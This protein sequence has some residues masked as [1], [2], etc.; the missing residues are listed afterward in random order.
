MPLRSRTEQWDRTHERLLLTRFL[1]ALSDSTY[2]LIITAVQ[3]TALSKARGVDQCTREL[4]LMSFFWGGASGA[5]MRI[6]TGSTQL[7]NVTIS[8]LTNHRRR[9]LVS[10]Q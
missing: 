4:R 10:P 6:V 9:A 5:G 2:L 7:T 1:F 8:P 3:W